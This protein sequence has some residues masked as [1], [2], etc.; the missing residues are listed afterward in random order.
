[1][2]WL[3]VRVRPGAWLA[4]SRRWSKITGENQHRLVPP[5]RLIGGS[6]ALS[7][8]ID[9]AGAL[10]PGL[11]AAASSLLS[12][13][14]EE[15]ITGI[16]QEAATLAAAHLAGTAESHAQAL[17]SAEGFWERRGLEALGGAAG[18]TLEG[19]IQ[20]LSPQASV[21]DGAS[22]QLTDKTD[23]QAMVAGSTP[24]VGTTFKP[25]DIHPQTGKTVEAVFQGSN[26][27]RTI[28]YTD[29]TVE[30]AAGG[31]A[32]GDQAN[33]SPMSLL[34]VALRGGRFDPQDIRYTHPIHLDN[35]TRLLGETWNYTP[36]SEGEPTF[37]GYDKNG[38]EVT[39]QARYITPERI[40]GSRDGDKTSDALRWRINKWK[41][42]PKAQ[43][44]QLSK[45]K[46]IWNKVPITSSAQ[47]LERPQTSSIP[48]LV[49]WAKQAL[50]RQPSTVKTRNGRTVALRHNAQGTLETLYTH[51]VTDGEVPRAA[52][53][54][55][56]W[57]PKL[58]ETLANSRVSVEMPNG[59]AIYFARYN[60][61]GYLD[62]HFVVVTPDGFIADH[63]PVDALKTHWA[64]NELK[65]GSS[66]T[67]P[68]RL[69]GSYGDLEAKQFSMKKSAANSS[70][71][72]TENASGPKRNIS[73]QLRKRPGVTVWVDPTSSLTQSQGEALVTS[74]LATSPTPRP[75]T[76]TSL[77]TL[78]KNT[79]AVAQEAAR[80]LNRQLPGIVGPKLTFFTNP[81]EL[82]RSN[83]AAE[84]SF[85]PAEIEQM[86]DA[87]G[88]YDN[89]TGYTIIFT[90]AI[91]VRPGESQR[92]AVA[93]V[94]LHERVGHDGFNA[95]LLDPAFAKTWET[96]A[97]KIP[98]VELDAI[99]H[100]GYEHPA[101]D[102]H[103]LALEW[104]A[105]AVEKRL[106]LK[107]GNLARRLW[108]A[109][110]GWYQRTFQP[111]AES[112]HSEAEL[113]T[114]ITKAQEAAQNGTAI[115]TTADGLRAAF[116][117][118]P[119][120]QKEHRNAIHALLRAFQ[121]GQDQP[122][123]FTHPELGPVS[124]IMGSDGTAAKEFSD[125]YGIN[126]I[127]TK[128]LVR[129]EDPVTVLP[130]VLRAASMGTITRRY[131]GDMGRVDLVH[132]NHQVTLSLSRNGNKQTWILTGFEL[133]DGE[134]GKSYNPAAYAPE[135]SVSRQQVVASITG[136]L[137]E[138]LQKSTRLQLSLDASS[139]FEDTPVGG[140]LY[141][142][143]VDSELTDQE[144]T[145][146][147]G[148][149]AKYGSRVQAVVP[150]GATRGRGTS[151]PART[152]QGD[153]LAE[154]LNR[155]LAALFGKT[156]LFVDGPA[157]SHGVHYS[158]ASNIL[159]V[160]ANSD[161][162]LLFIT[163]HELTHALKLQAPDLYD[164]LETQVLMR[165]K[166]R[167]DY[168]T[169]LAA[170]GYAKADLN[171]ESVADFVGSQFLEPDFFNRLAGE[172]PSL[173]ARFATFIKRFLDNLLGRATNLERD[174]R[175][176]LRDIETLRDIL[177]HVLRQYSE[178]GHF[179][180]NPMPGVKKLNEALGGSRVFEEGSNKP[181]RV[182]N[183]GLRTLL[184][185]SALPK[186]FHETVQAT[187]RQRRALDQVAAQIGLDLKTAIE[188]HATA[189]Q[190][191]LANVYDMVHQAMN[192]APGTNAVL[193]AI[194]PTL[195]E[196]VRVARNF[197]DDMSVA[198]A[199]TLPKGDLRNRIVF[200]QG[201]WMR[202]QYACFDPA[203]GWNFD[204]VMQAAREGK[205]V[206][207][208]QAR[209]IV[210]AAAAYISRQNNYAANQRDAHG[211]PRV[212][213][214]LEA[215]LRDLMDRDTFAA[216]LTGS[217][218]VRKNVSSLIARKEIPAELR[219]VMGEETNPLK[220]F[221]GSASFQAQFLQRHQ[222]QIALRHIGLANNLFVTQRAG[223]FTQEIPTDNPRW[224]PLAGLYTTPQLWQALQ[225]VD[226]TER[227]NDFW[228]LM[229]KGLQRLGAEAKL[230]KVA[231]NPDSWVVNALGGVTALVQTGDV[232]SVSLFS[233]MA[234][235]VRL[236]RAGKAAKS[237]VGA[238][239]AEAVLQQRRRSI[240]R[241][242]AEGVLGNTLTSRD[243]EASM[244]RSLLQWVELEEQ[245]L[246]D[247]LIGAA[248]GAIYGNAAGR[249]LGIA[250][251]VIGGTVGALAGATTGNAKI[252]DLQ[253]RLADLVMTGPDT[254]AR[255]TG[256]LGNLET[257]LA[258]GLRGSNAHAYAVERTRNTFPDYSK[259]PAALR[260]LS[261]YGLAGSFVAFQW[262]VYRNAYHNLRYAKQD[263]MSGNPAMQVR[264]AKR[265]I[266]ASMLG[267]LAAGG[268]QALFQNAAGTDDERNEKW[269][270]WFAA[271]W[272]KDAVLAFT[273][274]TPES[275]TYFNTSYLIPQTTIAELAVAASAG[276]DPQE[277]V[278]N[279]VGKGI[280]QFFG[281][282]VH[283]QPIMEA[284]MNRDRA[285]REVTHNEGTAKGTAEKLEHLAK[286]T[287]EPGFTA[288]IERLIYA[289]REAEKRGRKFSV[290]EEFARFVGIRSFTRTWPELVKRRYDGFA[291]DYAAIRNEANETLAQNLPGA[292]TKAIATATAKIQE[293][294]RQLADYEAD[295]PTLGVPRS[296]VDAARKNSTVPQ[297][298]HSL[299]INPATN[300]VRCVK[301]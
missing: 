59:N 81:A 27:A 224:S 119:P 84:N 48:A 180:D 237:A 98:E 193:L 142:Q 108:L 92:A 51:L 260:T 145:A 165:M 143:K 230:N 268:L 213:S 5:A 101:A 91:E 293:L 30:Q 78:V 187:E 174:I 134:P 58:A 169:S 53:D 197:I 111:F 125:G 57:V 20:L 22:E 38:A 276:K 235:A 163:G 74:L 61:G 110:K 138:E 172:Q 201:S 301:H 28:T 281:S 173:F 104:F 156:I 297:T 40:T 199:N 234:E 157:Q 123:A 4:F 140:F 10:K 270:K 155:Q 267:Y 269:R 107:E 242:T 9:T 196:R 240:A 105:R 70:G 189:T 130:G 132:G 251:R 291:R 67:S 12:E 146:L 21:T 90:D 116:T 131:G 289:Y 264:G 32:H 14:V 7:Q 37:F 158:E 211:L 254:V 89:D 36:A 207:T 16:A 106:H 246:K 280:E 114:L 113:R 205:A 120:P 64:R 8:G 250:G 222:Q 160:N 239:A 262:E 171:E 13:A 97:A 192:G 296:T 231:M 76:G 168:S 164:F 129:G 292:K 102:R 26:G 176:H 256:F 218:E 122:D 282:S 273:N 283:L 18:G 118:L 249:S 56:K 85:T 214:V 290:E 115:P 141:D 136:K 80:L 226:G 175:P 191:P 265:L 52:P 49:Q 148:Y 137:T 229:G 182:N 219:A 96:L 133:T 43:R 190:Q 186:A 185:G 204:N 188:A 109:L 285:G 203:S 39:V 241:L 144:R 79:R 161:Y 178:R 121:T 103:Q 24:A 279:L 227:G 294:A 261:K 210:A 75:A 147:A 223:V 244:D 200:N 124:I 167:A 177:A 206:G 63:G 299:E 153:H 29:G 71:M 255:L 152:T 15:P 243:L 60:H 94:I 3:S 11:K 253:A 277:V 34:E 215:D 216:V 209:S 88:F 127:I 286:A 238:A 179:S 35:G 19:G 135:G 298:F 287:L 25:G 225:Q 208:K 83:Y 99:I 233:R 184:T 258:A 2:P 31:I 139:T 272:E 166:R 44:L 45:L 150:T 236:H 73:N 181:F 23:E 117:P 95:L 274:Y 170:R 221:L 288:K 295:L 33:P 112:R 151:Q 72:D 195:A 128:R 252:R 55:A 263:I 62:A 271:P 1:M 159:V 245:T 93:R 247:R 66:R 183:L 69:L 154:G 275:V 17:P 228:S 198:I 6:Q 257:A 50:E 87:E 65:P 77:T 68:E 220:Q 248:K 126:G 100:D 212:G 194:N 47:R 300:R 54:R 202:R 46:D 86:Q 284:M 42:T 266:G 232:F 259:L 149:R 162:P 41:A 278:G 217:A 82:L